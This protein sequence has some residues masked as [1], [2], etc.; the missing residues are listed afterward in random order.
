MHSLVWMLHFLP[1]DEGI[2]VT[3]LGIGLRGGQI[4]RRS[5]VAGTARRGLR[6]WIMLGFMVLYKLIDELIT[7]LAV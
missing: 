4:G 6:S 1:I 7:F 2:E 3:H 5:S